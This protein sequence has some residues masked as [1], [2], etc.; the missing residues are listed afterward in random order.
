MNC[1]LKS[2]KEV[3]HYKQTLVVKSLSEVRRTLPQDV[4]AEEITQHTKGNDD[5]KI[6]IIEELKSHLE[7]LL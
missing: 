1:D 3:Q 5:R 2:S 6:I 4:T 7:E